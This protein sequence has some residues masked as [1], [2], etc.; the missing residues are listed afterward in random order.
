VLR[1][2]PAAGAT[3][4]GEEAPAGAGDRGA[5]TVALRPAQRRAAEEAWRAGTWLLELGAGAAD[6][7]VEGDLLRATHSCR[8]ASLPAL[9]SAAVRVAE[10]V[11]Q[12]RAEAEEFR[13][14]ALAAD[15][16]DLLMTARALRAAGPVQASW[17]GSARRA[18]EPV[19]PLRLTGLCSEPVVSAAGFAGV[20]TYL[21]DTQ[22]RLW[23]VGNVAP[24]SPQRCAAAYREPVQ[25][26]DVAHPH[27]ALGRTGLHVRGAAGS[28]DGRLSA[29]RGAA[30]V[31]ATGAPWDRE[32]PA[33]LWAEPLAAQLDRAWAAAGAAGRPVAPPRA[34]SDLLFLRC[35]V[36]GVREDALVLDGGE[37]VGELEGVAPNDHAELPYRVNLRLLG[38]APGLTLLVVGRVLPTR[39]RSLALLAAGPLAAGG[40]EGL[41]TLRL[42]AAWGGRVNLG[43]DALQ[44]A[45]LAGA[46]PQPA[47]RAAGS[48]TDPERDPLEA[49]LRRVRRAVA[50][51]RATLAEAAWSG[52]TADEAAL[53][54]RQLA[55]GARVLGAL[56][57]SAASRAAGT[58]R[59]RRDGFARAWLAAQAYALA[60]SS[61]LQRLSW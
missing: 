16:F 61:R 53:A 59:E 7:V 46:L 36:A 48:G 55:A 25:V 52:V 20:V 57:R 37:G 43:L 23:T 30:A 51:G 60:A 50:G 42:P 26:G 58:A 34:G 54:R 29:G 1:A 44:R 38:C 11:R 19:P 27:V 9:A 4:R 49:L 17:V 2:L 21:L 12:L 15:L 35:R 28:A 14:Q 45:Y 39:P 47:A 22:G 41:P 40:G 33:R 5:A 32:P 18:Y 10:R 3:E 24:G 6:A 31:R 8:L 56:R 13:L